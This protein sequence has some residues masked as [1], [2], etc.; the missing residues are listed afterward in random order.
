MQKGK[1][2][3]IKTSIDIGV[4]KKGEEKKPATFNGYRIRKLTPRECFRLMGVKDE[5]FDKIKDELPKAWLYHL[6]GD[7]IVVDV[8]MAMFRRMLPIEPT[9]EKEERNG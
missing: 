8:M 9:K 4:V 3:T 1:I 2:Q 6:A 7:S 5:D